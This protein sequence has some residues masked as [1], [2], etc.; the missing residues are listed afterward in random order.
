MTTHIQ[1]TQETW[2]PTTGCT[3]VSK[4]C[5]SCYAVRHTVRLAG[6]FEKYRGLVNPGKKHFNGTVKIHEDRLEKPLHWKKPRRIFVNSMSDLFHPDVPFDF[7]DKVWAVMALCPQHTFQV[8]TKRPERMAEY[9]RGV[10]LGRSTVQE[11]HELRRDRI[12]YT[13]PPGRKSELGRIV[14]D[15]PWP[16]PNVW[17]GTSV[18]DQPAAD[19]R[20]PHL[21]RCPAGVRFL[22]CEPLIGPVDLAS[23]GYPWATGLFDVGSGEYRRLHWI[24]VGGESGPNARPCNVQ[25]IRSLLGQCRDA[26][27]P[28]F[29]KQLG[30]LPVVPAEECHG[31][32]VS[33]I[34]HENVGDRVALRLSDK[35]GG[36]MSEWPE[37]LRIR[38]FPE[39]P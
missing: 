5:D 13:V 24:I 39:T 37:D 14:E 8:L 6:Q 9:L 23:A 17:V 25:W 26:G 27:V 15:L 31:L 30:A 12:L 21:L 3:R 38:E 33:F 29:I 18:E 36:R 22:S 35:K 20:I 7:V 28:V 19:E 4:G 11:G 34:Q 32:Q 1:W 2:N 16:L 10:G